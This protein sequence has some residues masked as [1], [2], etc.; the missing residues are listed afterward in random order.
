MQSE[1]VHS[2]RSGPIVVYLAAIGVL[3]FQ[4]LVVSD[5]SGQ[6][7]PFVFFGIWLT[8]QGILLELYRRT[9]GQPVIDASGEMLNPLD[10]S[11]KVRKTLF[12][13]G[14]IGILLGIGVL[15]PQLNWLLFERAVRYSDPAVATALFEVQATVLVV[16]LTLFPASRTF[17]L[18]SATKNRWQGKWTLIILASSGVALVALS[19]A[20]TLNEATISDTLSG[21]A[22]GL[23]AGILAALNAAVLFRLPYWLGYSEVSLDARDHIGLYVSS[24]QQVTAGLLALT[25]AFPVEF[26]FGFT[27]YMDMM[28]P[29]IG[30]VIGAVGWAL[31][32]RANHALADYPSVNS[33][34]NLTP[35]LALVWLGLFSELSL[36]TLDWFVLGA[37]TIITSNTL[38][39]LDPEGAEDPHLRSGH[40][41]KIRGW[42]YRSLVISILLSGSFM[43]FRDDILPDDWTTW[44]LGE[45]W[46]ML[47]LCSTVFVLILSFRI[48]RIS[49]RTRSED[50]LMLELYRDAEYLGMCGVLGDDDEEL[51]KQLRFLNRK[52]SGDDILH[53]YGAAHA[54]VSRSMEHNRSEKLYS[55]DGRDRWT[56][57]RDLGHFLARL[58]VFANMRQT[59]R[60]F[61]ELVSVVI[62]GAVTIFIALMLRPNVESSVPSAWNGFATE[63]VG[64]VIAAAVAFLVFNLF[65]KQEE[66]DTSILVKV[67]GNHRN[68][69]KDKQRQ[70]KGVDWQL[71]IAITRDLTWER[72]ISALVIVSVIATI[73]WMLYDKW[74]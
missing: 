73:T 54:I 52:A 62:F 58:D 40:D 9:R 50:A 13:N 47:A 5:A 44:T 16:L 17:A 34:Y 33:L 70:G 6:L 43:I 66:R 64:M 15:A 22:W 65:D 57:D 46:G 14:W 67:D 10:I 39:H 30:G 31:L 37:L 41:D 53:H 4:P 18:P 74:F 42:G 56:V 12:S 45:Y 21:A 32:Q 11:K 72:R 19:Q 48:S 71:N 27:N 23:T 1:L 60:E 24:R 29:F 61:A 8:T 2:R 59:G 26:G 20:D 55:R 36:V 63:L 35:L 3:S 7:S 68:Q 38:L 69:N 51:L 25:I 49:E 28:A